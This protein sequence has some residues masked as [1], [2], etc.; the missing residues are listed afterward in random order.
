MSPASSAW[1]R[2]S[3]F[4]SKRLE[5]GALSSCP[6]LRGQPCGHL[7]T[8]AMLFSSRSEGHAS[9]ETSQPLSE[10]LLVKLGLFWTRTFPNMHPLHIRSM[11]AFPIRLQC[12]GRSCTGITHPE[13]TSVFT[14]RRKSPLAKLLF[15]FCCLPLSFS[16]LFLSAASDLLGNQVCKPEMP[17]FLSQSASALKIRSTS[18][19]L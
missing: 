3:L 19:Y 8:H 7:Y 17:H 1:G 4:K 12:L 14:V 18:F 2:R 15:I 10:A 9:L 13:A 11:E 5:I 6:A 16:S